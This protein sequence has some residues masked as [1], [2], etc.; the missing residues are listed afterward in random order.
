[1]YHVLPLEE[2]AVTGKMAVKKL[3]TRDMANFSCFISSCCMHQ[4]CTHF[5]SDV[6]QSMFPLG[7]RK[8]ETG[9]KEKNSY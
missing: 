4:M 3:I 7:K 6:F 1:M 9:E 5:N 2:N 8:A